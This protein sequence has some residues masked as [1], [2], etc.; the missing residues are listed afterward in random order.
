M[1]I[2]EII[3]HSVL[4]VGPITTLRDAAR[5][6]VE[7]RVG[8]VVIVTDDGKPAIMTERDLMRAIAAGADPDEACVE[9]HMT[10]DAISASPSW[11]ILEA[12]KQMREGG[13]RHLLV[14]D[15]NGT[16]AGVLSMRDVL[17][18]LLDQSSAGQHA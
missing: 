5:A 13:F 17:W 8:S 12:S 15:E 9:D 1:E 11:D 14:M 4:T 2:G 10:P 18:A 6:M 16:I 7:R 3:S